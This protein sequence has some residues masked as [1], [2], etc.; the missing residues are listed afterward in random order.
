MIT[1]D[2]QG[3]YFSLRRLIHFILLTLLAI[4]LALAFYQWDMNRQPLFNPLIE[5]NTGKGTTFRFITPVE[6]KELTIKWIPNMLESAVDTY[7]KSPEQKIDL[8]RVMYCLIEKESDSGKNEN[9]GDSGK[10]CGILQFHAPT[11]EFYRKEMMTKGLVDTFGGR[12]SEWN[13]IETTVYAITQGHSK[14]WGPIK[15]G[16]CK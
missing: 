14:E 7:S 9:C 2:K 12:D 10:A 4:G 1:R 6:A 3:R 5:D 16:E 13:S 15:R 8:L 11:Y